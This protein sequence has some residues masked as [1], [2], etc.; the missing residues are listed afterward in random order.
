LLPNFLIIGAAK[1]GTTSL[2]HYVRSHPQ[3]FMPAKKELSFFCEEYNWGKGIRWYERNFEDSGAAVAVGE[4]SPRYTV[5]P[6]FRGVPERIVAVIPNVRLVYLVRDP[7][8]RMQSHYLDRVLHGL[9]QRPVEEALS[10][11][12]FYLTAS[13]YALQLDQYRELFPSKRILVVCSEEMLSER[14]RALARVFDFLGV[15]PGWQ[16]PVLSEEFLRTNQR[17]RPRRLVR[18]VWYSRKRRLIAPLLPRR[19]RDAIR[20]ATSTPIAK[21]SADISPSLRRRLEEQLRDDVRRLY[22]YLGDEF[23]GWGIA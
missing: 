15:D 22:S 11:D 10:T 5:Y 9:E 1:A 21:R 3:A 23:D 6:I 13:R 18:S 2:Y 19:L 20:D 8:R 7:I 4:A 16:A 17:R 14:E 12:P